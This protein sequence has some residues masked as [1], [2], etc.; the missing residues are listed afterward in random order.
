MDNS[1]DTRVV[2]YLILIAIVAFGWQN[3]EANPIRVNYQA[4]V[5][6]S[7]VTE[8]F[9]SPTYQSVFRST[10]L[11][12]RR[13]T[14]WFDFELFRPEI[15]SNHGQIE[16]AVSDDS[17]TITQDGLVLYDRN[18]VSTLLPSSDY[19]TYIT[20]SASHYLNTILG[21]GWF[22]TMNQF[23]S[24]EGHVSI[25]Q[26][27]TH[28]SDVV[29]WVPEPGPLALLGLGLLGMGLARRRTVG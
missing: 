18:Y 2:L 9:W 16:G 15:V 8:S 24:A 28:F 17:Y 29:A 5:T 20:D 27:L 3:A 1:E 11:T 19:Y 13:I 26:T 21:V 6:E 10:D 12:P 23:I 25:I 7:Y 4:T 22:S 14:G